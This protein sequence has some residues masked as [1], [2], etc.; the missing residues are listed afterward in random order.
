MDSPF[1]FNFN[2]NKKTHMKQKIIFILSLLFGLMFINAGLD[3]FFHYMP[4]PADM[5]AEMQKMGAGFAQISWLMPLVGAAELLGGSLFIIPKTRAL[6]ALIIFPVMVGILIISIIVPSGLPMILP[7][8]AILLWVMYENRHK[9][10][11]LIQ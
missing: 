1:I 11:A 5:P 4:Q 9:Y 2:K 8:L 3:K 7:F 10:F 6:G